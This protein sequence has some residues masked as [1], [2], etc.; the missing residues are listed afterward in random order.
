MG[1]F[2]SPNSIHAVTM[3]QIIR[4]SKNPCFE[5]IFR[6]KNEFGFKVAKNCHIKLTNENFIRI[7][8]T[9]LKTDYSK[10]LVCGPPGMTESVSNFLDG[11]HVTEYRLI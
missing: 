1:A 11:E 9:E 2:L 3:Q 10:V 4:L 8:E 7:L 5:V 6:F